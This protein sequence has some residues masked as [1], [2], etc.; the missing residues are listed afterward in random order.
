MLNK[1]LD[2]PLDATVGIPFTSDGDSKVALMGG[3]VDFVGVNLTSVL[4]QIKG[5]SLRALAV[6]TKERMKEMPDVP[7]FA[8]AGFPDLMAITGWS[9]LYGPKNMPKEAIDRWMDTVK[10]VAA[11]QSW[12]DVTLSL[13]NTPIM[14]SPAEAKDYV[15]NQVETFK[16]IYAA[17]K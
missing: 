14:N 16:K 9:G 12:R 2:L 7:T 6:S 13:G 1:I 3:N 15:R 4:D 10:K 8:E 5:G 11:D 17:G